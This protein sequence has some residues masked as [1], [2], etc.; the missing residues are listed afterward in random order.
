[1]LDRLLRLIKLFRC[2]PKDD[3]VM[4]FAPGTDHSAEAISHSTK[5]FQ[6]SSLTARRL[7][8]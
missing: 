7:T 4:E 3:F 6:S 2:H 5:H 8:E 1:V